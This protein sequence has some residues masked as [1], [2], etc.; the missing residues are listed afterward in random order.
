MLRLSNTSASLL[1]GL[2]LLGLDITDLLKKQNE[3][4]SYTIG[5]DTCIESLAL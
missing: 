4:K 3:G 2:A 5:E 1:A